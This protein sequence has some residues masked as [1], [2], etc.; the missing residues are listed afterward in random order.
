[1]TDT[2]MLALRAALGGVPIERLSPDDAL[3][4]AIERGEAALLRLETR[5]RS[6]ALDRL[7]A[8][9]TGPPRPDPVH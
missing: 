2:R 8:T 9:L 3:E 6:V 7:E 5:R 1:M 4:L